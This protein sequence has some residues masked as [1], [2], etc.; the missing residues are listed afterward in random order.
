MHTAA[1]FATLTKPSDDEITAPLSL[2]DDPTA[3]R[4]EDPARYANAK[5]LFAEIS[6]LEPAMREAPLQAL[7]SKG[8]ESAELAML[9][10]AL[11]EHAD[12]PDL[13]RFGAPIA[14]LLAGLV[15]IEELTPGTRLGVWTLTRKI[16]EGGMGSVYAAQRSDGHF[17]Q[18]AAIKVLRGVPSPTALAFLANERQILAGLTHPNI[19]R[20]LDGGATPQGQPYLV[21]EYLDGVPIDQ[22]C[23]QHNL[24]TAIVLR[25]LI[26]VCGAVS[27]A[28]SRLVVHCDLKPSNILVDVQ[29]RPF[30][31]DFG[32]ARLLGNERGD[33]AHPGDAAR[34]VARAFTPGCASPEQ[35]RGDAVSTL[36]DVYSLGRLLEELLGAA[37]RSQKGV[38]N[39]LTAA[40]E[41]RAIVA[42]ATQHEPAARYGSAA[43]LSRDLSRY[44]A[45]ETVQA[46]PAIWT[47]RTAKLLQRRWPLALAISVFVLTVFAFTWQLALD[48][49]RALLAEQRALAARD[50]ATQAGTSARQIG[51]FL[52]NILSSVDPDNARTMD[53][54]LMRT[55][56][57]QAATRAQEELVGQPAIRRQIETVV[58]DSYRA[59]SEYN[60]AVRHY[61]LALQILGKTADNAFTSQSGLE[62]EYKRVATLIEA[63]RIA[64]AA[65]VLAPTISAAE[66]VLGPSHELALKLRTQQAYQLFRAGRL[67]AALISALD[68]QKRFEADRRQSS[69]FISPDAWLQQL[70]IL[71]LLLSNKDQFAAAELLMQRA[72]RIASASFGPLHSRTLRA[73]HSLAVMLLQSQRRSAAIAL[74]KPLHA[75][76]ER[77]LGPA[78][79]LT[80]SAISNLGTALRT[81]GQ[82]AESEQYYRLAYERSLAKFGL[83][84][85]LTLDLA[86]NL[87]LYEIAAGQA[88]AALAR[89]QRV[90]KQSIQL[91]GRAHPS[92]VEALRTRAK[93]WAMLKEM[94]QARAA[95][96]EVIKLDIEVYG[97]HDSLTQMDQ[98]ALSTLEAHQ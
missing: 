25:L 46:M 91:H 65:A 12:A 64:E 22:Y 71:S 20:L 24:P 8:G 29:G 45:R 98:T 90:I 35:E 57:D 58:A 55:L 72:I 16:G 53:R 10:R 75:D 1:P 43:A 13:E 83:N 21:M 3:Q 66:K 5:V 19:A 52:A 73:R 97:E 18:L 79:L 54:T 36:S 68:T 62:L 27:F 31:L 78:A 37:Q 30:L 39:T 7:E 48:R 63:N 69:A 56:L 77:A 76:M 11:L 95:W 34:R 89:M 87:A 84:D 96:K 88:Q 67:K 92:S 14:G 81:N 51:A 41:L 23:R 6:D 80:I 74:L 4:V 61:E 17:E 93:A 50:Q 86:N 44:L 42:M 94:E 60:A 33:E 49:D 82:L 47:Y 85:A 32:I 28:H 9:V 15:N 59:I 40:R 2:S 26:E 70:N 38:K